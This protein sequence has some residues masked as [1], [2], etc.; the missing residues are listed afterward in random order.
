MT[1]T[2]QTATIPGAAAIY[3]HEAT[4]LSA[5]VLAMVGLAERARLG[6]RSTAQRRD[7]SA[8][9]S[10]TRLFVGSAGG[11]SS[12]RRRRTR[13]QH[14]LEQVATFAFALLD[15]ER[16]G[17]IAR[18][19]FDVGRALAARG[20]ALLQAQVA[21]L[22]NVSAEAQ[23]DLHKLDEL[24]L[25]A[26]QAASA[27]TVDSAAPPAAPPQE[28]APLAAPRYAE[29]V[30]PAAPVR[31]P[32]RAGKSGRPVRTDRAPPSPEQRPPLS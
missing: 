30:R 14:A 28:A 1:T 6:Q 15:L 24:M 22:D 4:R 8:S 3:A 20:K 31:R 12:A 2:L 7:L 10:K 9:A 17:Q 5:V 26:D 11:C 23:Q 13:Y 21:A 18:E 25:A 19:D 16:H 29:L 27:D 32:G